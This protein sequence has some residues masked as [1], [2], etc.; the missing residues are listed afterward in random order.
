MKSLLIAFLVLSPVY[1]LAQNLRCVSADSSVDLTLPEGLTAN[2]DGVRIQLSVRGSSYD[3][4]I[5]GLEHERQTADFLSRR[6]FS[7]TLRLQGSDD[8]NTTLEPI[9]GAGTP[10]AL[11]LGGVTVGGFAP[12]DSAPEPASELKTASQATV[13]IRGRPDLRTDFKYESF[14]LDCQ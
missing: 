4:R 10:A 5:K 11:V 7:Y 1:S 14:E 2:E 9:S 8:L 3:V 6:V 13:A 12:K